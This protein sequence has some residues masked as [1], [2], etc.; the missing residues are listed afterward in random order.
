MDRLRRTDGS[1][2]R[3]IGTATDVSGIEVIDPKTL[4]ITLAQPDAPFL[5][6]MRYIYVVPKAALDGKNLEREHRPIVAG[7][8]AGAL[9]RLRASWAPTCG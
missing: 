6:N 7:P 3:G 4:N 9:A 5:L 2:C 8:R 1:D